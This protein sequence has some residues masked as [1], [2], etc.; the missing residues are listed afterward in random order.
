MG[1][2]VDGDA[3]AVARADQPQDVVQILHPVAV[4]VFRV[5]GQVVPGRGRGHQHLVIGAAGQRLDG[6]AHLAVGSGVALGR[7]F[8]ALFVGADGARRRDVPVPFGARPFDGMVGLVADLP[9]VA[10]LGD[11]HE[12][13]A[14][15]GEVVVFLLEGQGAAG[16][17]GVV[18]ADDD[19]QVPVRQRAVVGPEAGVVAGAVVVGVVADGDGHQHPAGRATF[20]HDLFAAGVVQAV[21]VGGVVEW[22]GHCGPRRLGVETM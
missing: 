10:P 17:V 6:V 7:D 4:R 16:R 18:E 22:S 3:V 15:A 19:T 11:A 12:I 14:A 1:V 20:Q 2:G 21:E 8:L 9:E 13:G 5:V